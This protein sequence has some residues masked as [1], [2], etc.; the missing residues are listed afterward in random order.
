MAAATYAGAWHEGTKYVRRSVRPRMVSAPSSRGSPAV[1]PQEVGAEVAAVAAGAL[2]HEP[3]GHPDLEL[4]VVGVLVGTRLRVAAIGDTQ[5]VEDPGAH[6]AR[7]ER[8]GGRDRIGVARHL[9]R[10]R[11]DLVE[12]I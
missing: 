9:E 5:P 7:S 2:E 3:V 10:D 11:Q 8:H 4:E 1:P 12:L 6:R